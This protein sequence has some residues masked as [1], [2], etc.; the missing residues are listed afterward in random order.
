MSQKK[1]EQLTAEQEALIPVYR[2]KWR[3]IALSAEPIDYEKAKE[4]VKEVYALIGLS[5]PKIVFCDSPNAA[6]KAIV[7][8]KGVQV[9]KQLKKL[10]GQHWI[11]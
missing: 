11:Q 4:S 3:S 2:E 5:Q 1:I 10:G 7:S 6:L 8:Q 9:G